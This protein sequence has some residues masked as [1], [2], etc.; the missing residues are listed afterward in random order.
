M[1]WSAVIRAFFEAYTAYLQLKA[2]TFYYD[3]YHRS[4][5]KQDEYI[6]EIEKL[7][8]DRN[9]NT[10]IRIDELLLRLQQERSRLATVSTVYTTSSILSGDKNT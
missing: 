9:P 2:K 4:Y 6:K 1:T 8:I 10:H 5:E 3:I 7:R